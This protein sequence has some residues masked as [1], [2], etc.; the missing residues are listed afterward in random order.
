MPRKPQQ[1]WSEEK[2]CRKLKNWRYN[3]FFSLWKT[4]EG[5]EIFRF[6]WPT[7][8]ASQVLFQLNTET[9]LGF[10][11]N[12]R[13]KVYHNLSPSIYLSIFLFLSESVCVRLSLSFFIKW[14]SLFI[15]FFTECVWACAWLC[16]HIGVESYEIFV[17]VCMKNSDEERGKRIV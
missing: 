9:E 2:S 4:F 16:A 14:V 3:Q 11:L 15:S 5:C 12:C 7:D 10:P 8:W 6:N 1:F 13:I 17:C